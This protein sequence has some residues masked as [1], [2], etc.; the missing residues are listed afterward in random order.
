MSQPSALVSVNWLHQHLQDENLVLLDASMEK[1]VGIKPLVYSQFSCIPGAIKCDL[2]GLFHH[3]QATQPNTMPSQTQFT[4]QAQKLGINTDS[5]VVIYDNQGVYAS[6]RA[7]WMFKVMGVQ[8][9]FILNGGLPHWLKQKFSTSPKYRT[10]QLG[11]I[12]GKL[13]G[14]LL[15]NSQQVLNAIHDSQS[16]I[17]D[18]R[19]NTRFLGESPEPRAGVRSGHIPSSVNLPFAQLLSEGAFKDQSTLKAVFNELPINPNQK[20][21]FSCGSGITACIVL[22]A[23]YEAG[24]KNLSLYDGSWSEWGS[25]ETLPLETR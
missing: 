11:N 14:E 24:F 18:A 15:Q 3:A 21:I 6:P 7:W 8:N 23:A 12:V 1:V 25:D 2:E 9:V 22:V 20:L 17:F 13:Q 5:T 10:E 19:S 4:E 16:S